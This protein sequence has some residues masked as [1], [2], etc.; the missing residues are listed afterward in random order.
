MTR[1]R[2]KAE[3]I[4]YAQCAGVLMESAWNINNPPNEEEW[5][6]LLVND[7]G[8]NFGLEVRKLYPD[9]G[10]R[11]S[12]KRAGEGE[13]ARQLKEAADIYY[14]EYPIS[15]QVKIYGTPGD[16]NKFVEDIAGSIASLHLW[17]PKKIDLD[18]ERWMYLCRL[19]DECGAYKR[20]TVLS[21]IVGWVGHIDS[22]VVQQAINKKSANLPKYE[23]YLE[24]V[25]LL[26]VCDRTLN[27]GK[28]LFSNVKGLNTVG[29]E[30]VYLFSYPD[31]L[32]KI[33]V[34]QISLPEIFGA[35][36]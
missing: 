5:P 28:R 22:A 6:D 30:C 26:L 31:Q 32:I 20:W 23:S 2:Q 35:G 12:S 19:P 25:S 1:L 34:N 10:Y 15:V 36:D 4:L 29:F 17:Q 3:E 27:S 8:Q 9:E 24:K 13:R 16:P 11:G 18:D 14:Q 7:G 21:D 33:S